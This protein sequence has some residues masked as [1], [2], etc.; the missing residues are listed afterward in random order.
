MLREKGILSN[1]DISIQWNDD[2][3]QTFKSS[4]VSMCP[5]QVSI[6]EFDYRLRKENILLCGLWAATEKPIRHLFL[7]PFIDE[8]KD[9]HIDGFECLPPNFEEPIIIKVHIIL[10]PVDS[11]ERCALQNIHQFNGK[12]GCSLCLNPGEHVPVGN[13]YT[14][15]YRGGK[16]M[17]RTES[18]HKTDAIKAETED[19]VVNGVKGVSLLMLLPIFHIIRSFPPEY[20]HCVLLGVVKLFL[21]TWMDPKNCKKPWYIGTKSQ[22][23][24]NK[25][26]NMLPPCEITRTPQSVSNINQWKASEFK[27]FLI[28]YSLPYLKNLL[29]S[30]FL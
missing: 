11:V 26:L 22:I 5:L 24:D 10:A 18:Q 25:L 30:V 21:L 9:L 2:G 7:Q 12:Y 17:K 23:F 27:K 1:Y 13:G 6:N 3:V 4:K 15:V 20:M 29:L 16:G 28:Y 8:L 14:R 19:T